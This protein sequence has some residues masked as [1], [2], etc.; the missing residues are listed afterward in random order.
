MTFSGNDVPP[1]GEPSPGDQINLFFDECD[2]GEGTV[3]NGTFDTTF[4]FVAGDIFGDDFAFTID[5]T[6]G[7]TASDEVETISLD[8]D[9]RIAVSEVGDVRL[10]TNDGDI[11]IYAPTTLAALVDLEAEDLNVSRGFDIAGRI[12]RRRVRGDM[13][14]GGPRLEASTHD[15]TVTLRALGRR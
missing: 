5:V 13:N 11:T 15:G 10:R 4:R 7:F 14:G 12:T 6:A 9:I 3:L 1:L 8:G 2:D